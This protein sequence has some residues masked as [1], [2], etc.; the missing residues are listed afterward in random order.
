MVYKQSH[1][2]G[3][4]PLFNYMP[5]GAQVPMRLVVEAMIQQSDNAASDIVA[6]RVGLDRVNADVARFG[7]EGF[8]RMT[9][10]LEVRR[11]VFGRIDRRFDALGP[12]T[13]RGIDYA[14]GADS[15]AVKLNE[16]FGVAAGTYTAEDIEHAYAGYYASGVNSAPMESIGQMLEALALGKVV[17]RRASEA[18]VEMMLGTQTGE[19]RISAR[20]PPNAR[21]AHKT[22]TQY[23]R[24]CDVG[25]M[26]LAVDRPVV[27]AACLSGGSGGRRDAVISTLA[28]ATYDLLT[29]ER[30]AQ[31]RGGHPKRRLKKKRVRRRKRAPDRSARETAPPSPPPAPAPRE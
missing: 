9:S 29:P 30:H 14:K 21:I 13:I 8:G 7:W 1:V 18:M 10:L 2:R 19:G 15:K 23:R 12:S 31:V 20:L 27:F 3:G 6:N 4:S 17:S 5:V 24:T 26:Y 22:G 28:R 16:I 25:I 11:L